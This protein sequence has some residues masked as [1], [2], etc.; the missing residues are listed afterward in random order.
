MFL[1]PQ[2]HPPK[3]PSQVKRSISLIW[4]PGWFSSVVMLCAEPNTVT[5]LQERL[6]QAQEQVETLSDLMQSLQRDMKA[7]EAEL[8]AMRERALRLTQATKQNPTATA[9]ETA[10]LKAKVTE[11]EATVAQLQAKLAA[12][13]LASVPVLTPIFYGLSD[14]VP[15]SEYQRIWTDVQKVL[16][17]APGAKFR[18]TGHANKEGSED[19]NYR[20]SALRAQ[21][22]A[23]FL[24]SRGLSAEKLQVVA[25]GSTHPLHPADSTEGRQKNRRVVVEVIAD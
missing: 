17:Q 11:L 6:K 2:D 14:H 25:A 21:S 8:T 5:E 10:R 7:Q 1:G 4:I 20:Q 9:E 3:L 16:A 19:I 18:L 24:V 12:R 13:D 23:K 15:T 22:L